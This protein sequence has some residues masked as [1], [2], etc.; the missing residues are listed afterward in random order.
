MKYTEFVEKYNRLAG[1]KHNPIR[2]VLG[3]NITRLRH[4]DKFGSLSL[5]LPE[6]QNGSRNGNKE[7]ASELSVLSRESRISD[8]LSE[9]S[10]QLASSQCNGARRRASGHKNTA[11]DL[12]YLQSLKSH[13]LPDPQHQSPNKLSAVGELEVKK[14]SSGNAHRNFRDITGEWERARKEKAKE[15]ANKWI[16][17]L[18]PKILEQYQANLDHINRENERKEFREQIY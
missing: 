2:Y 15:L 3:T 9:N 7:D 17:K 10:E 18:A 6:I 4:P 1:P 12:L 5:K 13:N 8:Y 14:E 11:S 16:A